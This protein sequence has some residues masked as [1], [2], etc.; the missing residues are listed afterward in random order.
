MPKE[1]GRR[2]RCDVQHNTIAST[3]CPSVDGEKPRPAHDQAGNVPRLSPLHRILAITSSM[4]AGALAPAVAGL[5]S[6]TL[7]RSPLRTEE[8]R[9]DQPWGDGSARAPPAFPSESPCPHIGGGT[10]R[11]EARPSQAHPR[12]TVNTEAA[13]FLTPA[14][15]SRW[16]KPCA[17]ADPAP[18]RVQEASARR[19]RAS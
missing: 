1:V 18:A 5:W 19:S 4:R 16:G 6:G 13:P 10:F 9:A 3:A 11:I 12:K 2:N 7:I 15:E 17:R 14:G 8:A